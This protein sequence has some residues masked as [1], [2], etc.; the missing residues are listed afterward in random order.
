M[1]RRA[2]LGMDSRK[3]YETPKWW[4]GG[5]DREA[6]CCSFCGGRDHRYEDCPQRDVPAD[7]PFDAPED[8][9]PDRPDSEAG[10]ASNITPHCNQNVRHALQNMDGNP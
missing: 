6:M 5:E 10:P 9:T 3:H 8:V 7:R 1:A 4:P 2:L